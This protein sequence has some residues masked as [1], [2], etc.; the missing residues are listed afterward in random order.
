M[1]TNEATIGT[2][3]AEHRGIV[4]RV[5]RSFARNPQDQDDLIQE[6]LL[7]VWAAR[8]SFRGE[9]QA[10]TWMYRVALN[11]ALT[12]QRDETKRRTNQQQLIELPDRSAGTAAESEQQLHELYDMI[13]SLPRLDRSLVLLSLDGF[14]Y[15]E[16]ADIVEI[17]ESNVGARLTRARSRLKEQRTHRTASDIEQGES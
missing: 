5:A 17:S 2:V 3:I 4:V 7:R 13:R 8:G 11:Q 14:S 16:I 1:T 6:I 10:S 9:A 12:W 15:R